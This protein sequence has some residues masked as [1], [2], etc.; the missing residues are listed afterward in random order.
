[1][2]LVR[3]NAGLVLVPVVLVVDVDVIVVH[4]FVTMPVIVTLTK[5]ERDPARH[6]CPSDQLLDADG[7]GEHEGRDDRADERG[8]R[9][10]RGFPGRAEVAERE[11]VQVD[12]QAIADCTQREHGNEDRDLGQVLVHDQGQ[13]GIHGPRDA[14]LHADD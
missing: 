1:M 5:E 13:R 9:E 8:H 3:S 4:A 12:A 11:R 2:W 6:Q 10:H 7:L 14:N